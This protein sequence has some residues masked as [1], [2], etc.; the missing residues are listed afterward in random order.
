MKTTRIC[1]IISDL[2][3]GGAQRQLYYLLKHRAPEFQDVSVL[4]L[5]SEEKHYEVLLRG[6]GVNLIPLAERASFNLRYMPLIYRIARLLARLRPHIVH[7]WLFD[8]NICGAIAAAAAG[9]PRIVTTFR[10][11][12]GYVESV[13]SPA[14]DPANRFFV[15]ALRTAARMSDRVIV[16]AA[17]MKPEF[18]EW[19]GRRSGHITVIPNGIDTAAFAAAAGMDAPARAALRRSLGF[20]DSHRVVGIVQRIA[21]EKDHENFFRMAARVAEKKP[22]ARFLAV[23]A[24]SAD[25]A[26]P[27]RKY[28]SNLL[29]E[30]DIADRVV[31]TGKSDRVPDMLAAMDVAV[32]SSRWEGFSNFI[33]EAM[34]G[35]LPVAATDVS[36]SA[37][38]IE[39]GVSGLIVPPQNP[40]ALAA[41]VLELLDDPARAAD[42][43]R[44]AAERAQK[45]FDV[46]VMVRRTENLFREI[47]PR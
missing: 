35:G 47:L 18:T 34:A 32:N 2:R 19:M 9:V 29:D 3:M 26:M 33:L 31:F 25:P 6:A 5:P 41:A 1:H 12:R 22:E 44:R 40:E 42:M 45:E 30:L 13:W 20:D 10:I 24:V 14:V 4:Y 28:L 16:N 27:P 7:S 36:G 46:S 8:M 15:Q 17:Y 37:E 21:P 11:S 38:A 43:G 23:G 39:H